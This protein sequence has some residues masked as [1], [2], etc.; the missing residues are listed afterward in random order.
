MP[1]LKNREFN[2]LPHTVAENSGKLAKT[3]SYY[4]AFIA[5]GLI[6]GIFGPTLADLVRN[7]QT[8]LNQISIIFVARSLGYLAGSISRRTIV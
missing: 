4:L 3:V 5:L 8:T 6:T 1:N 2:C 7:T